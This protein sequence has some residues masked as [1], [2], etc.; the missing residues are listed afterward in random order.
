MRLLA[1]LLLAGGIAQTADV[2]DVD[3][4]LKGIEDR[5]NHAQTLQLRFTETYH[6]QGRVRVEKGELYLR[7]PGRMRWQYSAPSGKLFVSDG[8]FIYSY[9]PQENRAEKMKLKEADD[10]RAPLPFLLGRL[11]FAHDSREFPA[12]PEYAGRFS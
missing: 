12:Q 9:T 10:L 7:K 2:I 1:S 3:R 8:K 4:T 11:H 6:R 5:Y